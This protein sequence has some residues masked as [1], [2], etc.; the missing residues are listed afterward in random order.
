MPLSPSPAVTHVWVT[1]H[2]VY[3]LAVD[4]VWHSP[5]SPAS[6]LTGPSHIVRPA[7]LCPLLSHVWV[8]CHSVYNLAVDPVWHY[9]KT[10]GYFDH[11]PTAVGYI[12]VLGRCVTATQ[13][14]G[15]CRQRFLSGLF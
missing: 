7:A 4:P 10:E 14:N 9:P 2:S 6:V 8:T 13:T 1:C 11:L 3:N 5:T 15:H 12:N